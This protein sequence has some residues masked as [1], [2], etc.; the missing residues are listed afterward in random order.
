MIYMFICFIIG[1]AIGFFISKL[2][3]KVDGLFIVDDSDFSTTRWKIDV[4]TDPSKI[5][6]KKTLYFQ[7]IKTAD[8]QADSQ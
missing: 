8:D 1:A 2:T 5:P 3:R 6:E 4:H 7:V